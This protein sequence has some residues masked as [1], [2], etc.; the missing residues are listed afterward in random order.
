M[1]YLPQQ[2]QWTR[3]SQCGYCRYIEWK[4]SVLHAGG[5]YID[6]TCAVCMYRWSRETTIKSLVNA[7][8]AD[9]KEIKAGEE[10]YSLEAMLKLFSLGL[11]P[12]ILR[13]CYEVAKAIFM[14]TF[15]KMW[16]RSLQ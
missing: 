1:R 13:E 10:P 5:V 11:P 7:L 2:S 16:A 14:D 12:E 9:F 4:S 3:C 6:N 8:R 15:V